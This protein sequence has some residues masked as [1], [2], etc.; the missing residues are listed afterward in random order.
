MLCPVF[1]FMTKTILSRKMA[2]SLENRGKTSPSLSLA[3]SPGSLGG[4][5]RQAFVVAAAAVLLPFNLISKAFLS[6]WQ[7]VCQNHCFLMVAQI[8]PR[9][10]KFSPL[11]C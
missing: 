10:L 11:S 1:C 2:E 3:S 4:L 5:E 7:D 9:F 6:S 8:S